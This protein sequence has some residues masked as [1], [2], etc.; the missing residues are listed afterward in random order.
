MLV[1]DNL[2]LELDYHSSTAEAQPDSIY[3][4]SNTIQ[5]STDIR[6]ATEIDFSSDFPVVKVTYPSQVDP[7]GLC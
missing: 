2:T 6:A 3:G 7:N 4:N 1:N 5:M